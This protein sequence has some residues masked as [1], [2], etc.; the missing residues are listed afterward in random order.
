MDVLGGNHGHEA[1]WKRMSK[2]EL[3]NQYSPSRW[4]V[5]LGAEEAM[6][7]Y[8]Q[9]G[10]KAGICAISLVKKGS[11]MMGQTVTKRARATG[12]SL[13]DVPYGEGEGEKLDIYLP[14]AVSEAMPFLVFFHGGYWQSGSKDTSAFM[15]S[16][17]TAQ[18]VAVVMVAYDIAPKG[19]LD[20]MVDQVTQSIVFVQKR[21]PGNQ[22][23]Y[24][25]GHSAGAQLAAMMLLANWIKHGVTPNLKGFFLLSGVYDLEPI[26][27]TS[28]NAPLLP[29]L[30][31]AQRNSP[32]WHLETA[33]TQPA[34]PACRI[35]VIVGQHDS[36]EFRRQSREF[37]QTLCQ[38][39][40]KAS[41]AELHDV[42]HFEILWNLTQEDYVLTQI[43][44]KT[45][46]QES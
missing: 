12:R 38:G 15:V 24:L 29:T 6:R 43:I 26:M 32:L 1:P 31:D 18:G 40:W 36:P 10:S 11:V 2:E 33:P 4:V 45:I 17:L 9:I 16:P 41:F 34:D 23:I 46:F 27:H 28:E 39:G 19:T 35:L 21:Y 25:C 37:H 44:L 3:D 14:E 20:Q 5:R 30:E 13:L 7:T 22:G 42:D 8:S